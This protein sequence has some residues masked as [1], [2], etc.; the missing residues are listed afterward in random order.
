M[1]A[2]IV[3]ILLLTFFVVQQAKGNPYM[4]YNIVSPPEGSKPLKISVLSPISYTNQS[5]NVNVTLNISAKGTSMISLLDAYLTADWLESNTTIYKQN[6]DAPDFPITWDFSTVF[7]SVPEGIH[8]IVIYAL[9][10]GGYVTDG[11]WTA[12]S[13]EMTAVSTIVFTV[14]ITPPQLF[15]ASPANISYNQTDIPLNFVLTEP[16]TVLYS[17]DGDP[18][19]TITDNITL[20]NITNGSHHLTFYV[21]DT[22]GNIGAQTVF[23]SVEKPIIDD[24]NRTTLIAILAAPVA[25]VCFTIGLLLF[26]K[27]QKAAN[28][29]SKNKLLG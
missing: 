19:V 24:F 9:G 8:T 18:K 3:V 23:F 25:I 26:R 7:S 13:F 11:R 28:N 29:P 15:I 5:S 20:G 10:N 21:S 12:N 14:D 17:L 2:A 4:H 27:R 6:R 16:S 1:I 22:L